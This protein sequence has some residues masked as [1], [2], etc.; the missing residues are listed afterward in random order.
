MNYSIDTADHATHVRI[1][2]IA[3]AISLAVAVI[4]MA[5]R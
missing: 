3:L 1:V 4:A 2:V 5:I